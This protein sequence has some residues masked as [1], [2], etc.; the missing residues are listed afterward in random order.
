MLPLQR[1]SR[2]VAYLAQHGGGTVAELAALCDVSEMTIRRDL[3]SLEAEEAVQRTHG[4][5]VYLDSSSIE[6]PFDAKEGY[7]KELKDRIAACAVRRFLHNDAVI[8]LEGGTTV[9]GMAQSLAGFSNLTILTN[10]LRTAAAL[11]DLLPAATVMCSGGTLRE[12]SYTFL[13]PLAQQF[14]GRFHAHMA[15]FSAI[16][17]TLEE[18]FT[19]ADLLESEAKRAMSAAARRRIVLL[20]SAKFGV[21]S[22]TT[23]FRA[24]PAEVDVLVTD[25]GAPTEILDVVRDRGIEV[26]VATPPGDSKL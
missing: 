8:I 20:D 12:V 2:I 9:T 16:G 7:H 21:R 5:A 4:G 25:D 15:F 3:A 10:G 22:F 18:G 17:F 19:D 1:R 11:H 13:G 23:T 24:T 14:F 6:L 26:I